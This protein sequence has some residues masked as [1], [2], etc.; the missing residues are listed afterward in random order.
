[1]SL[2]LGDRGKITILL[3][4]FDKTAEKVV[5]KKVLRRIFEAE[6]DTEG[7]VVILLRNFIISIDELVLLASRSG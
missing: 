3:R 4:K 2:G 6:D 1:L 7:E 5:V